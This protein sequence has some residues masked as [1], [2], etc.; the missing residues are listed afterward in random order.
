MD[1]KEQRLRDTLGLIIP[2]TQEEL[3]ILENSYED[4]R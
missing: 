2:Y 4:Y 3:T 1:T